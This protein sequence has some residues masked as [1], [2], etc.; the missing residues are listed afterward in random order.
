M[1]KF[2]LWKSL[3][4]KKMYFFNILLINFIKFSD[5]WKI[6]SIQY[7]EIITSLEKESFM[8]FS[9]ENLSTFFSI[10]LILIF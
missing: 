10:L 1:M 6:A 9:E 3:F 2:P 7:F 4:P 5:N 8:V